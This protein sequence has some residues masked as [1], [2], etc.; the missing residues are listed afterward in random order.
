[1]TS[2]VDSQKLVEFIDSLGDFSIRPISNRGYGHMGATITD[3]I[4][5]AGLN[6][7]TVVEPRVRAVLEGFPLAT[8]STEFLGILTEHG[9]NKILGW[10]HP[11]KPRRVCELTTFFVAESVDTEE[12]LGQYLRCAINC[13]KLLR[14]N[15]IGPKT[16]DYLKNF[17]G[18]P[19]IAVDRHITNFVAVAGITCSSYQEISRLVCTAADL[20]S[21]SASDLDFAI[22]EYVSQGYLTRAIH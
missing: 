20:I 10:K 14:L 19:T 12:C 11:E 9:A 13:E 15:G 7:K 16:L 21:V 22:W 8:T 5:Q 18:I 1:V 2:I 6:Y 4:L 17:G 3:S